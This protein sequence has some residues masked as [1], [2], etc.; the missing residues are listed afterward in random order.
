[1]GADQGALTAFEDVKSE[2]QALTS[3]AM[4][5]I[6]AENAEHICQIAMHLIALSLVQKRADLIPFSEP[7]T[8]HVMGRHL[9][10]AIISQLLLHK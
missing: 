2:R 5:S 1:M 9:C 8:G 6:T 4:S 7:K 3:Q 10:L